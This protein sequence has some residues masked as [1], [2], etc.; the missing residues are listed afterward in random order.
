LKEAEIP[1]EQRWLTMPHWLGTKLLLAGI[2]QAEDLKGNING[3]VTNVLG[4]DMYE[5][6]NNAATVVL[7]G[8]YGCTAY[9]E[10]IV[11]TEA[12]KPEK[13]FGD[14]LKGLHVYGIK[15][16]KPNELAVGAFT[17]AVDTVI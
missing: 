11:E 1:K 15:V 13:R 12:F 17:E 7:A 4:P 9:A 10:Q 2:Y 3:F 14:A 16:V 5:S 6:G 8:S